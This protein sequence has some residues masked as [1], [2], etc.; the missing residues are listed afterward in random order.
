MTCHIKKF[1]KDSKANDL[2]PDQRWPMLLKLRESKLK[3]ME[4]MGKLTLQTHPDRLANGWIEHDD[5]SRI[6]KHFASYLD[7]RTAGTSYFQ[8][9]ATTDR[10]G[11]PVQ[12]WDYKE[13]SDEEGDDDQDDE[14]P[15]APRI[16]REH[17]GNSEVSTPRSGATVAQIGL[18]VPA[19]LELI[20][21]KAVSRS[22][23]F[24]AM[25]NE[26]NGLA[27]AEGMES[28]RKTWKW[29]DGVMVVWPAF[30]TESENDGRNTDPPRADSVVHGESKVDKQKV[31]EKTEASSSQCGPDEVSGGIQG[32]KRPGEDG[33]EGEEAVVKR[34]KIE[35]AEVL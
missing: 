7:G 8:S 16:K 18:G 10:S 24:R 31:E 19:H 20:D 13:S 12:R 26:A 3:E 33:L 9:T 2:T 21:G 30:D 14:E 27:A 4:D 5:E 1:M 32:I 22:F 25:L 11:R 29:I 34:I 17:L 28:V 35:A 6:R 23:C 15:D